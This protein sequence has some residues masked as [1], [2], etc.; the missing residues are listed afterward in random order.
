LLLSSGGAGAARIA[1]AVGGVLV[2]RLL[3]PSGRGQFAILVFLATAASLAAAAGIQFWVAREVARSHGVRVARSVV[4][5]HVLALVIALGVVGLAC[6][7]AVAGLAR[8]DTT[9]VVVTVVLAATNAVQLVFLALPNGLRAMGIVAVVT[10]VAA[11][12]YVAV[13]VVLLAADEP[14]IAAVLAGAALGNIVSIAI[15]L[16][17]LACAPEGDEPERRGLQEYWSAL[18]FGAPAGAGE[19]VLLAMLRADVLL[20]AFFLPL[21]A[22]G[23]YAVA[24]ALAEVL[25]IVPDGVAQVVLPTTARQPASSKTPMLLRYTVAAT[26]A[27]GALLVL[28]AVPLIDLV[29][30]PAFRDAASAVPLLAV[31]SIFGGIWKIVGSE[32]VALGRSAP[33]LTSALGGLVAMVA[34]DLVA[35]P[36]FGIVGAALGSAC[37]YGIAAAMV[38]RSWAGVEIGGSP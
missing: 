21:R 5:T 32:V 36:R 13:G 2:A 33:R 30:G 3:G 6:G 29:F 16:R 4:R 37:G 24:T 23:L 19:L 34:V 31:A 14:S 11:L 15:A 9:T 18:R 10:V 28:G 17:W 1:G 27:A 26:V 35:I 38:R 8:V 7:G 25:W 20:V 12:V 22:V